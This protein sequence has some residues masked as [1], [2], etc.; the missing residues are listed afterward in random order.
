MQ[1]VG[2]KTLKNRLSEYLRAVSRGETVLVTD[3][4]RVVAEI[5][6]PRVAVDASPAERK[7]AELIQQGLV[8]PAIRPLKGPP[9]RRPIMSFDELMTEIEADREDR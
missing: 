4:G 9:P 5:V 1:S 3:R 6:P 8:R 7:M 2:I